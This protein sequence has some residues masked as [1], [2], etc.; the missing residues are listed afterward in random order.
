M[1]ILFK[2][3]ALLVTTAFLSIQIS[4][5]KNVTKPVETLYSGI[6]KTDTMGNVIE[7]D[8]NDWQPRFSSTDTNP[9]P[10]RVFPAYPN[11][12]TLREDSLLTILVFNFILPEKAFVTITINDSL[13]H[14]INNKILNNTSMSIGRYKVSW[15]LKN[16]SGKPVQEGIYRLFINAVTD[17]STYQSY[18]DIKVKKI[19]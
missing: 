7:D 1:K 6:C 8:I 13:G 11:P 12:V 18:G 10:F 19:N 2:T 16:D 15:N 17:D 9:G 14:V 3:I 4:C 5:E